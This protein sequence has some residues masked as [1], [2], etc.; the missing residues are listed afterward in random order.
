[1]RTSVKLL[2]ASLITVVLCTLGIVVVWSQDEAAGSVF[3]TA[4]YLVLTLILT[5]ACIIIAVR[6]KKIR[7]YFISLTMVM[8]C[9]VFGSLYFALDYLFRGHEGFE[10]LSIPISEIAYLGADILLAAL[11]A[12]IW[13]EEIEKSAEVDRRK[14]T[15]VSIASVLFVLTVWAVSFIGG[16]QIPSMILYIATFS[17]IL[18]FSVRFFTVPSAAKPFLPFAAAATGYAAYSAVYSYI[19]PLFP[20]GGTEFVS[21]FSAFPQ[22]LSVMLLLPAL[23]FAGERMEERGGRHTAADGVRS[24][25]ALPD[26]GERISAPVREYPTLRDVPVGLR[27]NICRVLLFFLFGILAC[28]VAGYINTYIAA[29]LGATEIEATLYFAPIAEEFLKG[30]PILIFFLAVRPG[31]KTILLPAIACGAGFGVFETVSYAMAG[32]LGPAEI[33]L[34]LFSTG[35]M[36]AITVAFFAASLWYITWKGLTRS[37][38]ISVLCGF[39]VVAGG[40]TC[41]GCFNLL[42]NSSGAGQYFGYVLPVL[43]AAAFTVLYIIW[44]RGKKRTGV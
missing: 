34:R 17:A 28:I 29:A 30:I 43:A 5:A 18:C 12:R 13:Y 44:D 14:V 26:A 15:A 24:G 41:H 42:M 9:N 32:G 21:T 4:V 16:C 19:I 10:Y 11:C 39:G 37:R 6:H 23:F 38:V 20:G 1:M 27:E 3:S 8:A 36:H 25:T 35:L 33:V 7:R 31:L 40:I 22:T 2:I